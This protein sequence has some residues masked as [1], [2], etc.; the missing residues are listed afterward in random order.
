MDAQTNCLLWCQGPL[1]DSS[2]CTNFRK[3]STTNV[4]FG[5][6]QVQKT[7]L[8]KGC[9]FLRLCNHACRRAFGNSQTNGAREHS[10]DELLARS[11]IHRGFVKCLH[12]QLVHG[13]V[14]TYSNSVLTGAKAPYREPVASCA[15]HVHLL[16]KCA[17]SDKKYRISNIFIIACPLLLMICEGRWG[18]RVHYMQSESQ[19]TL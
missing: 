13:N 10:R 1:I 7:S 17:E 4:E 6:C 2:F 14:A 3:T 11:V 5:S 8:E 18:V 19:C 9:H 15:L 16:K 12:V